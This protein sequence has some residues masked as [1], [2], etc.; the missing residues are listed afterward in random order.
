MIYIDLNKQQKS[1]L[2]KTEVNGRVRTPEFKQSLDHR[3]WQKLKQYEPKNYFQIAKISIS[4]LQD[5]F[6][7]RVSLSQ[8]LNTGEK[9]TAQFHSSVYFWI[10]HW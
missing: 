3:Q 10:N 1:K 7:F 9:E 4:Q 2:R 8:I 5:L 6:F